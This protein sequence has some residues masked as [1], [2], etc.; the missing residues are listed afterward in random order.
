MWYNWRPIKQIAIA[1]LKQSIIIEALSKQV[2]LFLD[3]TQKRFKIF[4]ATLISSL[5]HFFSF[6]PTRWRVAADAVVVVNV[7][8][9]AVATFVEK[10]EGHN[11]FLISARI[12]QAATFFKYF[13]AHCQASNVT[14]EQGWWMQSMIW[15]FSNWGGRLFEIFL[16]WPISVEQENTGS[17]NQLCQSNAK[18][19]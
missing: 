3:T 2:Q 16:S 18:L 19:D 8:V 15:N 13:Y 7:V 17:L 5:F 1:V 9:A 6:L 14:T 10:A 4:F 11:F 12:T